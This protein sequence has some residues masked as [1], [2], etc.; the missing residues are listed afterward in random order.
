MFLKA[1]VILRI[2]VF[3]LY[4]ECLTLYLSTY[5][6]LCKEMHFYGQTTINELHY[7]FLFCFSNYLLC[8]S[9]IELNLKETK[10]DITSI[11]YQNF[12]NIVAIILSQLKL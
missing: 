11:H 2:I 5:Q 7:F 8:S 10:K 12:P 6:E 3:I 4:D 9:N 1:L